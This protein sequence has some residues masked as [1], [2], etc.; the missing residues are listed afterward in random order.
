MTIAPDQLIMRAKQ[1]I[2]HIKCFKCMFCEKNLNTGDEYGIKES[3]ILCR[4]HFY[5]DMDTNDNN[6]NSSNNANNTNNSST[7]NETT[8]K[9][10]QFTNFEFKQH[11]Q[12]STYYSQLFSPNGTDTLQTPSSASSN[13]TSSSNLYFNLNQ[14]QHYDGMNNNFYLCNMPPTPGYSPPN[15]LLQNNSSS[16]SS[17]TTAT[18]TSTASAAVTSSNINEAMNNNHPSTPPHSSK[19]QASALSSSPT[20]SSSTAAN[21]TTVINQKGR[22][23]KRKLTNSLNDNNVN[24]NNIVN[25]SNNNNENNNS[26]NNEDLLQLSINNSKHKG[27]KVCNSLGVEN[28][29]NIEQLLSP[30]NKKHSS[31]MQRHDSSLDLIHDENG[32]STMISNLND[33]ED[34]EDN[35]IDNSKFMPTSPGK[36]FFYFIFQRL[37]SKIFNS[38]LFK[39]NNE[40]LLFLLKICGKLLCVRVCVCEYKK[41]KIKK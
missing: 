21:S 29:A 6:H 12:Q 20:T 39:V 11:Q 3:A 34:D 25:S 7:V 26:S 4:N 15:S 32:N 33:D 17:S 27:N 40:I 30:K 41:N 28:N 19:P 22:P 37:K 18:T 36:F 24:N 2:F 35:S 16:S 10:E 13:S 31:K 1:Y 23:K 5:N 14:Q 9:F 38:R 8:V